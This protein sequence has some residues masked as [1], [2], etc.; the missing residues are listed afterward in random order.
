MSLDHDLRLVRGGFD[1]IR[2]RIGSGDESEAPTVG[3]SDEEA[4]VAGS[5]GR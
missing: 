2:R 5:P 4:P 3:E 1:K